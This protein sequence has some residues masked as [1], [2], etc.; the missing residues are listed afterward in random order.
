[1]AAKPSK[2]RME[3]EAISSGTSHVRF[4][5][6]WKWGYQML[7]MVGK[8]HLRTDEV[9]NKSGLLRVVFRI[10]NWEDLSISHS[11]NPSRPRSRPRHRL[12]GCERLCSKELEM[13]WLN[14]LFGIAIALSGQNAF[15]K[16]RLSHGARSL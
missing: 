11:R 15:A 14:P 4:G 3:P 2:S 6:C 13:N 12:Q 8:R 7:R 10:S 9:L 1:M 16:N 5:C